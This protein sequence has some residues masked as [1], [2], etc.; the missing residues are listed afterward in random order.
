MAYATNTQVKTY[1]GITSTT[2][3]TL[4]TLLVSEAQAM[5]DAVSHRTFE[6]SGDTTRKFDACENVDGQRLNL[7]KDLCAITSITNGDGTVITTAQYVTEPRNDTPYHAITLLRSSGIVWTYVNDPENAISIVGKWA[8]ATS[9]PT[10]I[11]QLC[12][13]AACA[14]YRLR[15][16]PIG[17][18][19]VIEGQSFATPKDVTGYV[20]NQM[21]LL[22]LVKQ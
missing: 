15:E 21:R 13:K 6:A 20:E 17:E 12:I 4:I 14:L 1:L 10:A 7:D 19:V 9:A 18:T 2:D 16:N 8:Y 22:G 3:D 5:I 11:S